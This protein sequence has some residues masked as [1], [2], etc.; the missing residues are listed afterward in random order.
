MYEVQERDWNLSFVVQNLHHF[1][2]HDWKTS[3]SAKTLSLMFIF[4]MRGALLAT[5]PFCILIGLWREPVRPILSYAQWTTDL[6]D[7]LTYPI[8][9]FFFC[10]WQRFRNL[11]K[12]PVVVFLDKLCIAQH[13]S[14][15]KAKGILGLATFLDKSINLTIL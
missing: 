3:R 12:R 7:L 6:H 11:V 15:Q 9:L 14:E 1:L 8:F 13:D 10:F 5:L 2:S 4:N